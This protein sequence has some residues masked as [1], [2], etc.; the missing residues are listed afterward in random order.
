MG[1]LGEERESW[2]QALEA[3]ERAAV[4]PILQ[5]LSLAAEAVELCY[6]LGVDVGFLLAGVRE[7][8]QE[9][10]LSGLL[11]R[12]ILTDLRAVWVSCVKGYTSQA[13]VLCASLFENALT[14][15]VVAGSG[16]LAE[17]V[18][19]APGGELP[20]SVKELVKRAAE[21]EVGA[22]SLAGEVN[23]VETESDYMYFS[24]RWL[25]KLKHPT[26][27]S[28]LYEAGAAR[29]GKLSFAPLAVPDV[30]ERDACNKGMILCTAVNRVLKAVSA[31]IMA[32][33]EDP[34][35]AEPV[36][37]LEERKGRLA[38]LLD[39]CLDEYTKGTPPF[40]LDPA[41]HRVRAYG[42]RLARDAGEPSHQDSAHGPEGKSH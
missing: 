21:H 31:M 15:E 34:E 11:L 35:R 18:I 26:V 33:K 36:A 3:A 6:E 27:P 40:L 16:E 1:L 14:A 7:Q 19:R 24:Y 23:P 9:T 41:S 25:C 8:S 32:C 13:G 39:R 30:A 29:T 28:L 12:R 5:R 17:E 2:W 38:E 20:W 10:R 22:S 37:E 42:D 4:A